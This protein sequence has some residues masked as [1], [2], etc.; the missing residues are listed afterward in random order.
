MC[1]HTYT[2]TYFVFPPHIYLLFRSL[3]PIFLL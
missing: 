1:A 3:S 2:Y